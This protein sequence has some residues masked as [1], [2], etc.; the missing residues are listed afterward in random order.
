MFIKDYFSLAAA[1]IGL[2]FMCLWIYSGN[3]DLVILA[4]ACCCLGLMWDH[5]LFE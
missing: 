1:G 4:I 2:L 3:I 5:F